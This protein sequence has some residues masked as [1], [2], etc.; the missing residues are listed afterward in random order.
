VPMVCAE[1]KARMPT[2]SSEQPF[3]AGAS[4]KQHCGFTLLELMVVLLLIGLMAGA[5][6]TLDFAGS[7][8]SQQHQAELLAQQ[9][10]L[11]AQE[12][13]QSGNLWALDFYRARVG[14]GNT[15]TGYRWLFHDG[16]RWQEADPEL[17]GAK[18]G[19]TV[20]PVDLQLQLRV[21]GTSLEPEPQQALV[22]GSGA[23][24]AGFMPEI[25]LSPTRESTPFV[26]QICD[27]ANQGCGMG[28]SVDA[29]GRVVLL[30]DQKA[31]HAAR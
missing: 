20:L 8:S 7:P 17:L 23:A 11:A 5:G 24:N 31:D 12:A 27:S 15:G 18:S 6:L 3:C 2:S 9:F 30:P 10:R 4:M 14:T 16:L 25:L 19:A 29:L 13:V 21:D 1:V 22:T 28:V 26:V